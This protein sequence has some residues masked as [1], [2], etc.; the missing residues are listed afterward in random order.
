MLLAFALKVLNLKIDEDLLFLDI[1]SSL[2]RQ[3][4]HTNDDTV[5]KVFLL[6]IFPCLLSIS[7]QGC[8]CQAL[9]NHIFEFVVL[10]LSRLPRMK[11]SSQTCNVLKNGPDFLV[12]RISSV[13]LLTFCS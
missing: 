4:C 7:S 6:L 13:I 9:L 10:N 2:F 1:D 5:G 8:G 11:K 12:L 3:D